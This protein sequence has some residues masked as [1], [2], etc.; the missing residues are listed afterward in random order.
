MEP[1]DKGKTFPTWCKKVSPG[2]HG[3]IHYMYDDPPRE[4]NYV[5][6]GWRGHKTPV[7]KTDHPNAYLNPGHL[8]NPNRV[9]HMDMAKARMYTAWEPPKGGEPRMGKKIVVEK[10]GNLGHAH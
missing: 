7:F 3:W 5:K 4:D 2:W 10:E 6:P 8:L 9:E 1:A